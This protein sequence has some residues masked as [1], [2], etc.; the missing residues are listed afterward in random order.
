MGYEVEVMF[1]QPHRLYI[2]IENRVLPKGCQ[3]GLFL[4]C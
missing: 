4:I 2:K 3:I 1:Q